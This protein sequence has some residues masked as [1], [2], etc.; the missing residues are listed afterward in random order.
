MPVADRM[1]SLA[2]MRSIRVCTYPGFL[3][4]NLPEGTR[5]LRVVLVVD[6]HQQ[7]KTGV[8]RA[9]DKRQCLLGS[10]M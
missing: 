2:S 4:I 3:S 10:S 6:L 8:R 5:S 1:D 9:Q 7:L